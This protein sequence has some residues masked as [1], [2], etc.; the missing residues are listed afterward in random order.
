[1]LLGSLSSSR[2]E[3]MSP[4]MARPLSKNA[5]VSPF[6]LPAEMT[7]GRNTVLRKLRVFPCQVPQPPFETRV[8]MGLQFGVM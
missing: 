7:R 4:L 3:I 1:M 5:P 2:A 8:W 6:L